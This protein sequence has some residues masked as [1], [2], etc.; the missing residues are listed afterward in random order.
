MYCF[1]NV[2]LIYTEF[3]HDQINTNAFVRMTRIRN[4]SVKPF[5]LFELCRSFHQGHG[6]KFSLTICMGNGSDILCSLDKDELKTTSYSTW[7]SDACGCVATRWWLRYGPVTSV[8]EFRPCAALLPSKCTSMCHMHVWR[9]L[10]CQWLS[11]IWC[12]WTCWLLHNTKYQKQYT[13]FT[14]NMN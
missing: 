7:V 1:L 9:I 14:K 4:L 12:M 11:C 10:I 6:H 13:V 3:S 5:T 8:V 2:I